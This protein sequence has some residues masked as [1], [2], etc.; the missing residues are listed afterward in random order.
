LGGKRKQKPRENHRGEKTPDLK[1]AKGGP[2]TPPAWSPGSHRKTPT[3]LPLGRVGDCPTGKEKLK[4]EERV[5]F[6]RQQS[7]RKLN[8]EKY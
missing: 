6:V 7:L 4:V 1:N 5:P 8:H 2:K 3:T